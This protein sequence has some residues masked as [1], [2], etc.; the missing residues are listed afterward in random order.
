[1]QDIKIEFG[2]IK[3]NVKSIEIGDDLC[4]I[5]SGGDNPHIGCVTLSTPRPSLTNNSVISSTTS[6][7]NRISHKDDE[8]AKYVSEQL[9]SKLNKHVSV[10]CGI[11]VD[12]ITEDEIKDVIGHMDELIS[13]IE[14][15]NV[16]VLP[17]I[18]E[19]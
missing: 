15:S 6:I 13:S 10:I 9:S 8:V 16:K 11:H 4:V 1:M 17:L 2:R 3:I 18:D 7:L 5:I 14:T 19:K 12:N